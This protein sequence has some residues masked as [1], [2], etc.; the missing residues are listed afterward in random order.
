MT[1]VVGLTGGIGSGKSTTASLLA[2]EGAALIDTDFIARELV[3]PTQPSFQKIVQHFGAIILTPEG[4]IDRSKLRALVFSEAA[5]KTWLEQLLHPL[6]LQEVK[7]QL[8]AESASPY[9]VVIIP[10]LVEQY[11]HYRSLLHHI[12]VVDLPETI[13][14]ARVLARE[15][16][17]TYLNA[18]LRAQST[19]EE[20]RQ[21]ADT[22]LPND[23]TLAILATRVSLLHQKLCRL[24]LQK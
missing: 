17:Q 3:L 4:A 18:I 20:R 23:S 14:Y 24:A 8:K 1:F 22:L 21:I 15:P 16:D 5:H 9:C 13:Q 10:L 6:I 2:Q 12:V 11:H 7:K 19:R